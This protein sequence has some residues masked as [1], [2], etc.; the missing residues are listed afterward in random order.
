MSKLKFRKS[1]VDLRRI[2]VIV[3]ISQRMTNVLFSHISST[4]ILV[5]MIDIKIRAMLPFVHKYLV[6]DTDVGH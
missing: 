2:V 4:F 3:R 1:Y 5:T 6:A